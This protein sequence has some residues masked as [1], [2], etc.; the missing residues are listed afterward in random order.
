MNRA[1]SFLA[2]IAILLGSG[3]VAWVLVAQRPEPERQEVPSRIPF[4]STALV[5]AGSGSI[6]VYGAGTVRPRAE[7]DVAAEITGRVVWVASNFQSGGRV[8]ADQLLFRIDDAD[9]RNTV[10]QVGASMAVQEL[11]LLRVT[12]EARV[13]RSQYERFRR[14]REGVASAAETSPL[15][16]WEPQMKAA[17]ATLARDRAALV[18]AELQLSRTEVHAP[19][20]GIVLEES[21]DVG[22]FVAAGRSVGRLYAAD[23]VEVVVPLSDAEAALIPG[24]WELEAGSAD[25]RVPVRVIA[26]YG[27]AHYV[28]EGYVD[29]AEA[30]LDEMTRTI[31][32]IVRVPDPFA[33][34]SSMGTGSHDEAA[35]NTGPPL[36]VGKF[37]EVEIDGLAPD[38]YFRVQRAALR[39]GN[40]VWAVRDGTVQIVPVQVLQRSDDEVFL[41]GGLEAGQAVI[42]GGVQVAIDGMPVRTDAADAP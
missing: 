33:G 4:A 42:V 24:L 1:V 35:D 27:D 5:A 19:F 29:R 6:P 32:V 26:E 37:V 10:E 8:D 22:Q 20:A 11:E 21:L 17:E 25:P 9:Y 13:A 14:M 18:A 41:T 28:W 30:A 23:A 39:P 15:T 31:D 38:E 3:I 34:G 2:V 40:E 36:L 12:E 16:L 7:V